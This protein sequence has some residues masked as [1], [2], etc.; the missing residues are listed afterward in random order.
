MKNLIILFIL[1][2]TVIFTSCSKSKVP[3]GILEPEKMQA[4]YWDYLR[5]DVYANELV[6]NDTNRNATKENMRLQKEIFSVHEITKEAFYKS[7]DFYLK[8]P[9]LM[10]DMLDTMTVR[11][12]K[13]IDILAGKKAAEDSAARKLLNVDAIADSTSERL[14]EKKKSF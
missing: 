2:A 6:R 12:Q 13:K 14:L 3:K 8:H 10:K 4:V 1:L 11:Q 9:A 5:A 7:Y